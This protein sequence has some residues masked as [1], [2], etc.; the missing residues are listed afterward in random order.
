MAT[1]G[2]SPAGRRPA[3][4]RPE[5]VRRQI[6]AGNPNP[7]GA[8]EDEQYQEDQAEI[9][10]KIARH[11]VALTVAG[12]LSG[13][14]KNGKPLLLPEG[15]R[16]R[17]GLGKDDTARRVK[18]NHLLILHKKLGVHSLGSS[19]HSNTLVVCVQG[20]LRVFLDQ[21]GLCLQC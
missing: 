18:V 11:I 19:Y 10:D 4:S 8:S 17:K 20:I 16:V 13:L 5:A 14:A 12:R 7:H 6:N 1:E 15:E 2:A 21:R 3:A 9:R